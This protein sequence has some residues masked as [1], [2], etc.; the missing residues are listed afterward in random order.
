M[1]LPNKVRH[2]KFCFVL[3]CADKS[4]FV[5]CIHTCNTKNWR[6]RKSFARNRWVRSNPSNLFWHNCN[7]ISLQDHHQN[8][9]ELT[10]TSTDIIQ[11]I[12]PISF[13]TTFTVVAFNMI[14]AS[15]GAIWIMSTFLSILWPII[16]S[17]AGYYGQQK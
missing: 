3:F 2:W 15:A 13:Y 8:F 6:V 7:L 10:F 12:S 16:V 17:C 11:T 14:F 9:F 5:L 1:N 4:D